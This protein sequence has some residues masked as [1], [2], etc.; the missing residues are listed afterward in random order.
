MLRVVKSKINRRI[1]TLGP[2][3]YEVYRDELMDLVASGKVSEG[4]I[5][6]WKP[7]VLVVEDLLAEDE[8]PES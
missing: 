4:E 3:L 2:D 7:R 6:T 8:R 1:A 5:D